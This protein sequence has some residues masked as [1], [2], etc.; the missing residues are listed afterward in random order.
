[1]T[2]VIL[3]EKPDQA[4]KFA[5]ALSGE[6]LK[7]QGGYFEF[8]SDIFGETVV[9]WAIG[10]LVGLALPN[11]YEST[12]NKKGFDYANIPFL[13]ESQNMK[14]KVIE[15]KEKQFKAV[16]GQLEKASTIIIAT[17]PDREGENIAYN[18][19]K[20]CKSS[21][22]NKPMKRLWINS[23]TTKELLRGFQNLRDAVETEPFFDEANARQMADYLVGM[24]YSQLFTLK[25]RG[26]GLTNTYSLGRLQTPVNTLVVENDLSISNFKSE[27]YQQYICKTKEKERQVIFKN[28][29][30]YFSEEEFLN[31]TKKYQLDTASKGIITSKIVEEK[32]QLSPKLFNLGGIQS[33]ANN[34]WKFP[35]KKTDEIIQSLY[36][37]E[38]LSYPRTDSEYITNNEFDYL[39]NNLEDY[40]RVLGITVETTNLTANKNYVNDGKVLEHYALI[41]TDKI[42][43]LSSLSDDEKKVYEVVVTRT[44]LMFSQPYIYESTKLVLDV[45]GLE[46][47]TTGNRPINLGWKV[48]ANKIDDSKQEEVIELP[49]F[50]ENEQ[51]SIKIEQLKKQ[52]KPPTRLTEARLVG[53]GGLMEKMNLGTQATR[54]NTVETLVKRGY[55]KIEATKI[56][57]T[58]TGYLLWDLT[59]NRDLLIG[60]PEMTAKWESVLVKIGKREYTK[61]KFMENIHKFL[62]ETVVRLKDDPFDSD[63]FEKS[64]NQN[65]I[66]IGDYLLEDKGALYDVRPKDGSGDF[67]L[68]KKFSGKLLTQKNLTDL[69]TKGKTSSKVKGLIKKNK[70]KYEAVIFFDKDTKKLG[71]EKKNN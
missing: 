22:F 31:D 71:F 62:N 43:N 30:E 23:L 34:K 49:D 7:N 69:L 29:I 33:F 19:F 25:L 46:F 15:G 56:T 35:T 48:I 1:M 27:N 55:I 61:I 63:Y 20:L 3:A 40:K 42:P 8:K 9:T 47:K 10:H 52:T 21:I 32:Q 18:I 4:K 13:P 26:K 45:N 64:I 65:L 5:S 6:V 37:K 51:I 38:Y 53:K 17:D 11:E 12:P 68:W 16:K 66:E 59:K 24:N 36:Q 60:K 2:T 54:S 39:L 57:P 67:K 50:Q 44:L 14:Y 28:S 41:P 70:E 58:A